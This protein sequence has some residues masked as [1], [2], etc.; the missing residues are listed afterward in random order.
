MLDGS[1]RWPMK[2]YGKNTTLLKGHIREV[3]DN[4]CILSILVIM[5]SI[6]VSY[7]ITEMFSWLFSMHSFPGVVKP[8]SLQPEML[9]LK[10]ILAN[11]DELY[12]HGMDHRKCFKLYSYCKS[13]LTVL[14]PLFCKVLCM[15]DIQKNSSYF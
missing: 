2:Y 12:Q 4:D 8:R 15:L 5:L 11:R 13:C 10:R 1:L 14:I 3:G 6:T 7:I 9:L